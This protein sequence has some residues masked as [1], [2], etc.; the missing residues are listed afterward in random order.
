MIIRLLAI[1]IVL[2]SS[3]AMAQG[4]KSF[5]QGRDSWRRQEDTNKNTESN[6]EPLQFVKAIS[7]RIGP[8]AT[9][10]IEN[11]ER[12]YCYN[13]TSAPQGFDGYTLD[14]FAIRSFCGVL[15]GD[16]KDL[17]QEV[18][19]GIEDNISRQDAGC[20]ISPQVML[21]FVRGVDYVDALISSPC[22]SVSVFYGG[23]VNSFNYSPSA[24][25]IDVFAKDFGDINMPFVSPALLNQ[26]I[27]VGMPQT[28]EEERIVKEAAKAVPVRNWKSNATKKEETK[29]KGWNNLNL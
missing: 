24:E 25:V 20:I 16:I 1:A 22:H 18:L 11:A 19:F 3:V 12:V 29:K 8:S 14:G 15:E 21:R 9:N 4:V 27:P 6:K 26:V 10:V 28:I 2:N 23:S 7:D 13:V 5:Q 17:S